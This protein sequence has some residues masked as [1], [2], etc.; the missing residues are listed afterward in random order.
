[1]YNN[2]ISHRIVNNDLEGII[3]I[4]Q[5]LSYIPN[6][7]YQSLPIYPSNDP[8]NRDITYIPNKSIPYDPRYL[9]NGTIDK[10][11]N[12]LLTGFFDHN[13]IME[14]LSGWSPSIICGR[15]RLGGIPVGFITVDTH[16]TEVVIPAD[17]AATD[18]KEEV[19]LRPAQVW[20]PDSSYKTAQAM[21]DLVAED[22]PLIIFA[23]WRGFSG[24][25]RD[26]FDSVLKFGSYIV[27]S[28]RHI[29]QPIFVYLPPYST[30]RGGAWVVVDSKINP[31]F[32][33]MYACPS[34]RGGI[35]ETEGIMD[36]KYKRKHVLDKAHSL[37][38]EL[39]SLTSLLNETTDNNQRLLIQ[40]DINKREKVI[41]SLYHQAAA[42]FCDLHDT[43]GRMLGKAIISDIIE[44]KSARTFFYWKLK[45]RLAELKICKKIV[46]DLNNDELL[47]ATRKM[48]DVWYKHDS[49]RI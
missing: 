20:Y 1:M 6:A 23:N 18:S 22:L 34:A 26:M 42:L 2:G 3:A 47:L 16:T 46:S 19:Q 8:I 4:L 12:T 37:D 48:I 36:V 30:L 40:K 29:K 44:W 13:S 14:V 11:T 27:D 32:I 7:R 39:K 9:L 41:Y 43:P 17:P 10:D 35:L 15:A 31:N 28:L 33:E 49:N 45:M 5:W 38:Q 21:W 24:G 25:M